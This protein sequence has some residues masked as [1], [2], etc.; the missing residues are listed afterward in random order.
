VQHM[1]HDSSMVSL[2]QNSSQDFTEGMS[3]SRKESLNCLDLKKIGVDPVKEHFRIK[4]KLEFP[5]NPAFQ[6][7]HVSDK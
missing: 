6:K 4:E 5:M 2:R 3:L 7:M 1:A